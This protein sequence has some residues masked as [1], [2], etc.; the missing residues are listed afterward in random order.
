MRLR[1]ALAMAAL[2]VT[3]VVLACGENVNFDTGGPDAA[4][5][6]ASSG[7]EA[8]ADARGMEAGTAGGGDAGA[9]DASERGGEGN[10]DGGCILVLDGAPLCRANGEACLS[11]KDCCSERCEDGY[12][13]PPN[14]CAAPN[15]PCAVRSNCCSARCE[16]VGRGG[17]LLCAQ[18]CA[19][20][21]THCDDASDCCSLACHDGACGGA[22]CDI[23]GSAC[24]ENSDC[25]SGRCTGGW[26]AL[27]FVTC[28]PTGEGCGDDAGLVPPC[29]S[30][31]CT[32]GRCDSGGG[33]CREESVPCT[34]TTDCCR[35]SCLENDAGVNVCH[36]SCISDGSCNSNG[37]CCAGEVC[38]G[39][40][41]RCQTP[42]RLCP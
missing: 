16:P 33:A 27:A 32:N 20:D 24:E 12:C 41:S 36:A 25:C 6:E 3:T 2:A 19:A 8:G 28:S 9:V 26:C 39:Q 29:C 18:F 38:V 4:V 15:M 37:D 40:P 21:G 14:A 1:G 17:A 22:L 42:T 5:G 7:A 23:V 31:V 30:G 10:G 35:G 34:M 11:A 13:L